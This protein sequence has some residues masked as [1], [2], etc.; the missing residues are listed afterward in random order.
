MVISIKFCCFLQLLLS[1]DEI[2]QVAS[3]QCMAAILVHSPAKYAPAFI[4]ADIP[5]KKSN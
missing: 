4:H 3:T 2:L 5:G 1:R